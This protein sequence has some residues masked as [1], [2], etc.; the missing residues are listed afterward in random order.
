MLSSRGPRGAGA[1]RPQDRSHDSQP[2]HGQA[3]VAVLL[4]HSVRQ[5]GVRPQPSG[6]RFLRASLKA[7]DICATEP[8][9]T[10]QR[11][12]DLGFTERYDYA[13]QTLT[14][15]SY[16][17]WREFDPE[18]AMRFYA[19]RLHE[20]GMLKSSPNTILADGTDWRFPQRAQARAKA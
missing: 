15:I 18:D 8:E 7:A 4:L 16:A 11:L 19:L 13:L 17:S 1:A 14:E 9:R 10:A 2:G 3:L 20:V 6:Q 5:P 12:V